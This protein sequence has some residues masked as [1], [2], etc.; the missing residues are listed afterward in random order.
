M[1]SSW[2]HSLAGRPA[3]RRS[4]ILAFGARLTHL[5]RSPFP[6]IWEAIGATGGRSNGTRLPAIN[7]QDPDDVDH[8]EPSDNDKGKEGEKEEPDKDI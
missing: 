8:D 1:D 3:S 5:S 6:A 2:R 4:R 7:P